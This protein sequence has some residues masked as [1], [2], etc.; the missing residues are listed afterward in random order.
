M[1]VLMSAY[2]PYNQEMGEHLIK[3]GDG[4]KDVAFSVEDLEHIVQVMHYFTYCN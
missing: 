4:V 3:H 2:E 1:L